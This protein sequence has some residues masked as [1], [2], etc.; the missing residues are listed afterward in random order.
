MNLLSLIIIFLAIVIC[1]AVAYIAWE[2]TAIE[3]QQP[4]KGESA[5]PTELRGAAPSRE[6][7]ASPGE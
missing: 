2:L 4:E 1:V 7:S 3:P 6:D 5:K